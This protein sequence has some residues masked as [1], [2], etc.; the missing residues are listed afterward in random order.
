MHPQDII[1]I[2]NASFYAYHGVATDEQ[3]LGGK[4]EVDAE[5]RADLSAAIEHD[6]LKQ[7]IDYEA[8]YALIS[9]IVTSKKYF[10]VEALANTIAKGIIRQFPSS[11]TVTVRVRKPHPPVKGVVDY[12]E[13]EVTEQR[14]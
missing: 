2:S 6:S 11:E 10:L 7:T 12:V 8:V 13:V 4:F 1:R 3:T 5:I 14:N 9:S